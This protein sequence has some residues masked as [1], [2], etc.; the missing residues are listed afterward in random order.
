MNLDKFAGKN[1]KI[2][3]TDTG[4]VIYTNKENG[5]QVV[6]D[7]KGSYFRVFDPSIKGK[8]KYLD[9]DGKVPSNKVLPSGKQAGRSHSE[10][11]EA[12][13]FKLTNKTY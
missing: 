3:R 7:T 12:T 13:H 4:K 10:Y 5:I 1:P 6:Y 2:E 8:R 11:N 9:L